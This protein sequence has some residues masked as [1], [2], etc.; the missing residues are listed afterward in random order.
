[1]SK[2]QGKCRRSKCGLLNQSTN[3][4]IIHSQFQP[5]TK[6][7]RTS[8]MQSPFAHIEQAPPDPIIG[9]TEA[10]NQDTNANKVN[11][12][13]GV[14]QDAN[15]K[16]PV[17]KV[18]RAAEAQYYEQENTKTYLPIDGLAAYNKE[19]QRLLFGADSQVLAEGRAVTVQGLGG[20][21]SL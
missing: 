14:Y 17:L 1:M 11:L 4:G 2:W 3:A 21:G 18:V 15:G 7:R 9:L 19:V 13:V 10:F 6:Q 16:V 12:G 8:P 5:K 20:T